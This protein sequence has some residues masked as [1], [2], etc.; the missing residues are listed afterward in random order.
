MPVKRQTK[1][2]YSGLMALTAMVASFGIVAA[3]GVSFAQAGA[4]AQNGFGLLGLNVE[5]AQVQEA[6]SQSAATMFASSTTD[7]MGSEPISEPVSLSHATQRDISAPVARIEKEEEA[8][9]IAAEEQAR[10]DEA[11]RIEEAQVGQAQQEAN[12][13]VEAVSATT[14]DTLEEV[15]WSIGREAFIAEWTARIDAYLEGTPLAGYGVNFATA[16]WEN[17]V[18]PRWSPAISNT[19]SSNGLHCFLPYNAWGWGDRSWNS[20][21]EAIADHVAGLA[22]GY[23]YSLTLA[24]AYQYCPP[25]YINWYYNTLGQMSLI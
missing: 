16:A 21:E 7:L 18:D 15:D 24:N 10:I 3:F 9:R 22:A 14:M 2:T 8:A 13:S 11:N 17:S 20:W 23:G 4:T 19:E 12:A 25:N 1:R 5:E 6:K